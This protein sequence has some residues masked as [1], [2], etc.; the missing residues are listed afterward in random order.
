VVGRTGAR[1][2]RLEVA[3]GIMFKK[4]CSVNLSSKEV[5][6]DIL[7]RL[8]VAEELQDVISD[9]VERLKQSNFDYQIKLLSKNLDD[10]QAIIDKLQNTAW[11][12]FCRWISRK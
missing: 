3:T 5:L 9:D 2:R 10:A 7:V 12:R 1:L 4:Q 8:T 6:T 11:R